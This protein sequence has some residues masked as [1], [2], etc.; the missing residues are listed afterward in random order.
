MKAWVAVVLAIL[1]GGVAS[2]ALAKESVCAKW[3]FGEPGDLKKCQAQQDEAKAFIWRWLAQYGVNSPLQLE[4]AFRENKLAAMLV[5][6]CIKRTAFLSVVED[7]TITAD[8]VRD[9]EK[10]EKAAGT[11]LSK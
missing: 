10:T 4:A 5:M 8:C 7:W 2:H 1:T 9:N 11:D 3:E 6:K